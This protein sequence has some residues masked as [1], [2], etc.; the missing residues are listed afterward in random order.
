MAGSEAFYRKVFGWNIRIRGDGSVAFDDAVGE[1]RGSWGVVVGGGREGVMCCCC[2]RPPTREVWLR[3]HI[4][5]DSIAVTT[6]SIVANGGEIVQPIGGD[7]PGITG[8]VPDF[9]GDV[10]V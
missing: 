6:A 7:A 5:V 10:V 9:L 2:G 3:V 1:G 8:R 4:M